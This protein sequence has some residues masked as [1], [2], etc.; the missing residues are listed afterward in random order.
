[1]NILKFNAFLY[2]VCVLSGCALS[3]TREGEKSGFSASFQP[4]LRDYKA[5][6]ELTR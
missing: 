2:I 5:I 3:Y 4:G 6:K 1:M